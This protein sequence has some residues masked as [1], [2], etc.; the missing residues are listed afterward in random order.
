V[1]TRPRAIDKPFF[2]DEEDT[3]ETV[4][5]EGKGGKEVD[6]DASEIEDVESAPSRTVYL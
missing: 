5:C 2:D 1:I 4:L 3:A 6:D